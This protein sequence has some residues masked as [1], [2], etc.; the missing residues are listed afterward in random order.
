MLY[1]LTLLLLQLLLKLL[2]LLLLLL[3]LMVML[4]VPAATG[5]MDTATALEWRSDR[6][7]ITAMLAICPCL[8]LFVSPSQVLSW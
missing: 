3:M 2:L 8:F 1:P 7:V 5:D 4:L 6:K